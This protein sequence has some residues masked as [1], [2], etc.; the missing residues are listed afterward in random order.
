MNPG[1]R[2]RMS[3]I[4]RPSDGRSVIVAIDHGGIAGPIPGI[5]KPAPLM[6]ACVL[7]GADAVLTTRGFMKASSEEWAPSTALIL[8][9]TGGFTVLG[10]R[11]EEERISSPETA[12]RYAAMAAAVTVKF[13][14]PREGDF[15][16]QASLVADACE[17]WNLPLMIEA[18][19]TSKD[20]KSTDPEGVK[21]AARS[22]QEIG[23]DIVKSYYTGDPDSFSAVVEG[24]PAPV[25]ILGGE[26][27]DDLGQ[28]F[29]EVHESLQ[30]G[31]AGIA[32]GRNIWQ[33]TNPQSVVEAMAGLVHDDWTV[34]QALKH[35][36]SG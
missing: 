19:A 5:V 34:K 4:F 26:K 30:A 8:R 10:G 35:C 14:H 9:L 32:I 24:C 15:I 22:A 12:L 11:F 31:G 1:K 17:Q 25:V 13:G 6:K 27:T 20:L 23:A 29:R 21:L 3:S 16:R 36:P 28:V 2:M 33:H 7:G 18:M